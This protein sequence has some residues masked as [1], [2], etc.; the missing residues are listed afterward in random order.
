MKILHC[1]D[2]HLGKKPFG[3]KEYSEIRYNDYFLAFDK[4]VLSAIE[5]DIEVFLISG[6]FFDK[7]ELVPQTLNKAE[8]SLIKLKENNI[9]VLIIEGNHD[10]SK[11]GK[12]YNSWINYLENKGYFKKLKYSVSNDGEND[13]YTFDKFIK[14]DVNFYGLGYPGHNI[15]K[16]LNELNNQLNENENNIV[17]VH[18][19]I[20]EGDF[21]AGTANS[22]IIDEFKGK[23]KYMAGGHFHGFNTYPKENSYFFVPGSSEYWNIQNEKNQ[24]KGYIIFD[25]EDVGKYE[26]F[27]SEKRN[28]IIIKK[29]ISSDDVNDFNNEFDAIIKDLFINEGEDIIILELRI[30]NNIFINTKYCEDALEAK[31]ALK[32]FVKVKYSSD[33]KS[34]NFENLTHAEIEKEIIKKWD[35]FG[36][37]AD[38]MVKVMEKLKNSQKENNQEIF[39]D[40]FNMMIDSLIQG[41]NNE[42]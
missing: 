19:A 12:E 25:S 17:M 26:F 1:S 5:K 11:T 30:L 38:E 2:I 33:I 21:L 18:T 27:E 22:A 28:R 29:D 31:G 10:N 4:I 24:K 15:E 9:E 23:V 14:A 39:F 13:I 41:D 32:T 40:Y 20:S 3:S 16:V 6:D 34:N 37:N 35:V 36:K 7:K 8:D 42:N